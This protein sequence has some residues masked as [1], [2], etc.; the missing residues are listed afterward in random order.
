[1][2]A[3]EK[4]KQPCEK[5]KELRCPYMMTPEKVAKEAKDI[6]QTELS[7]YFEF[8]AGGT[9]NN[10]VDTI[11]IEG[12]IKFEYGNC[13]HSRTINIGWEEK[14]GIGIELGEDSEL[15]PLNKG[16]IM[17]QFYYSFALQDLKEKHLM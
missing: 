6:I 14:Y 12:I 13:N 16:N 11:S 9:L 4:T 17:E 1:M 10:E 3:C 5:C 15:Y 7:P 8:L 2:M